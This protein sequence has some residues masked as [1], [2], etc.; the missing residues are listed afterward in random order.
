MSTLEYRD[1]N[2]RLRRRI[3]AWSTLDLFALTEKPFTTELMD[4]SMHYDGDSFT[5]FFE[6][7]INAPRNKVISILIKLNQW[8]RLNDK[9]SKSN[10]LNRKSGRK[11]ERLP[12]ISQCILSFF[13]ELKFLE[14]L[15]LRQVIKTCGQIKK[16]AHSSDQ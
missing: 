12:A 15:F 7:Y 1:S 9:I 11:L 16:I 6:Y 4:R 10:I 2:L 13:F 5:Y 14:K 3:R 8:Y